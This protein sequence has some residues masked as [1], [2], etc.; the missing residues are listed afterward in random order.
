VVVSTASATVITVLVPVTAPQVP[1]V[2][3]GVFPPHAL[4]LFTQLPPVHFCGWLPVLHWSEPSRHVTHVPLSQMGFGFVQAGEHVAAP[5]LP[6]LPVAPPLPGA[7]PELV[8]PLPLTPPEPVVPPLL[9][10]PEPVA[11]PEPPPAS[12]VEAGTQTPPVQTALSGH[13]VFV[14]HAI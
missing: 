10:P 11:P 2:H 12:V 3:A 14:V 1:L 8:P 9:V 4:P 6:P 7:P 13:A 5:P